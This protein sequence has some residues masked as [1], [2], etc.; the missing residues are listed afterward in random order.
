MDAR[1]TS[2]ITLKKSTKARLESI[3]GE[4]DWDSFFEGL[5]FQKRKKRGVDSLTKLRKL[6]DD[7]DLERISKSSKKFRKEFRLLNV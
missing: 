6:L 7:K 2:T 5:C 1:E 4:M 3:K